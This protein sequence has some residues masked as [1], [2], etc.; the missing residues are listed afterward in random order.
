M[1]SQERGIY[2]NNK[3]AALTM[4]LVVIV[5]FSLLGVAVLNIAMSDTKQVVLQ[6]NYLKS[7]YAA[8][9]GADALASHIID[10]WS[11]L[12]DALSISGSIENDDTAIERNFEAEV[13]IRSEDIDSDTG[14]IRQFLIQSRGFK[15]DNGEE[16]YL[17][18]IDLLVTEIN[19]MNFGIFTDKDLELGKLTT[20]NVGTNS[21]YVD[22][23]TGTDTDVDGNII[24]GPGATDEE[25]E[26]AEELL[27]D[28]VDNYVDRLIK[29]LIFPKIQDGTN[30]TTNIFINPLNDEPNEVSHNSGTYRYYLTDDISDAPLDYEAVENSKIL[31][32]NGENKVNLWVNFIDLGGELLFEGNGDIHLLVNDSINIKGGGTIRTTGNTRV[33]L[34]FNKATPDIV[35][36][37]NISMTGGIY[38]PKAHVN[39]NGTGTLV[40]AIIADSFQGPT[41]S[42]DQATITSDPNMTMKD[43]NITGIAGYER[44]AWAN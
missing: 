25:I 1:K 43:F 26:E 8:R 30:D 18:N 14:E 12:S 9:S 37:G 39:F 15:D 19:L 2:M 21:T 10:D 42:P 5:V 38:A 40:G 32:V 44:K 34:Y 28:P 7:F 6:E 31:I 11:D 20:G 13:V 29:P 35:L 3:G 24:L 16:K 22:T 4:V 41:A 17:R 27:F 23:T 33:F 36:N